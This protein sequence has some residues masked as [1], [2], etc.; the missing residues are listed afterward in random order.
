MPTSVWASFRA[1]AFHRH[2]L[3]QLRVRIAEGQRRRVRI[4]GTGDRRRGRGGA[5]RVV[6]PVRQVVLR[7]GIPELD[8]G[9][10]GVVID[11]SGELEGAGRAWGNQRFA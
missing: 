11:G 10:G 2:A 4:D 5:R 9:L 3:D 1:R 7:P 6:L 8:H